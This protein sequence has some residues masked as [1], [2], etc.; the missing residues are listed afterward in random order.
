MA[1]TQK[2]MNADLEKI[3]VDKE[4]T[5]VFIINN[6]LFPPGLVVSMA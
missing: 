6:I 4:V 2:F 1:G 5:P 3:V